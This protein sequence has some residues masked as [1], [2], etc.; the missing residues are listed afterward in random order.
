MRLR[1]T[2]ASGF[3]LRRLRLMKNDE[4]WYACVVE[5]T[6]AVFAP[7][8]M[9]WSLAAASSM[10]TNPSAP[11]SKPAV[12]PFDAAEHSRRGRRRTNHP[13]G[14]P[15]HRLE[16]TDDVDEAVRAQAVGDGDRVDVREAARVP[17][18]LR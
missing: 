2:D 14:P 8:P 16:A 4:A 12:P 1:C 15:G 3:V 11:V 5:M 10:P 18:H 6:P 9:L 7:S 13:R 17:R